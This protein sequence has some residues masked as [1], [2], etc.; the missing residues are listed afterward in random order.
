[1]KKR[2]RPEKYKDDTNV[3]CENC[4]KMFLIK[5]NYETRRFCNKKCFY[6]WN[7][8]NMKAF[9]ESRFQWKRAT[10]EEILERR[11]INFESKVIK[12]DGCWD[13]VGVV[14]KDG[15]GLFPSGYHRTMRANRF[16]FLMHYGDLPKNILVCHHCDNPRCTN[17][18][19]LFLG[20][21]KINSMDAK[22]K[23]RTTLGS[24]NAQTKLTENDVLEIRRLLTTYIQSKEICLKYDISSTTL[25]NI[26]TGK[27]WKH[28]PVNS[29]LI[30][31]RR[32]KLNDEAVFYIKKALNIGISISRIAK[33]FN[34]SIG[35]ITNIKFN[36]T[37]KH[38][39]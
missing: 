8:K 4:G 3:A 14:D 31:D 15:Y 25:N 26:K 39:K 1:M 36:K 34:V 19:H 22:N 11:K 37:W 35:C 30:V 2:T 12:K 7:S 27:S 28:I 24:K 13:W 9:N 20:T 29:N 23:K 5:K 6:E 33:D 17:P 38:I 18:E 21:A 10:E 16:S 32:F